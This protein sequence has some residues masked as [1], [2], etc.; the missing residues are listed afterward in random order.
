MGRGLPTPGIGHCLFVCGSW[1]AGR[2]ERIKDSDS[3]SQTKLCLF[4]AIQDPQEPWAK[5][6]YIY[7]YQ[8]M[9]IIMK[10]EEEERSREGGRG[11]ERGRGGV[12]EEEE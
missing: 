2:G 7:S 8:M 9:I 12:E 10:T 5:V 6:L 1:G 11:G 3:A 4:Y